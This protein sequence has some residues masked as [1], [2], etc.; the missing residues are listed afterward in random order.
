M[1]NLIDGVSHLEEDDD[2]DQTAAPPTKKTINPSLLNHLKICRI[3]KCAPRKKRSASVRRTDSI[4]QDVLSSAVQNE[5]ACNPIL[6][7]SSA[8]LVNALER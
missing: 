3:F 2:D 6:R 1:K 8:V 4:N 7:S 5:G